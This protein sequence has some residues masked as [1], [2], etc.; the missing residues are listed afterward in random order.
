LSVEETRTRLDLAQKK[1]D[2]LR[3]EHG[4]L[5]PLMEKG[6]ITRDEL[7][8][9]A[10]ELEQAEEELVL[11][12]RR[13]E[14]LLEQTRPRDKQRAELQLAQ[15]EAQRENVRARLEEIG[16]RGQMLQEQGEHCSLFARRPG[17]VVFEEYLAA[18][19]RRKIRV[20]DR[21]TGSQGL[22]TIPEVN[23]ML[24]EASASEADVHRI[25]PGQTAAIRLEAF[26]DLR[27]T[28]KVTRVGTLARSDERPIDDKRFDVTI[29][30]DFTDAELRPEMTARVDI[31]TSE[32]AD[33]LLIPV[34]AV[35]D[36]QGSP[37]CHVTTRRGVET[38]P[39]QLGASSETH[40]EVVAGLQE[41]ERV[42]LMDVAGGEGAA[43]AP[44]SLT[45]AAPL[46]SPSQGNRLAPR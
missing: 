29:E 9:T 13:S 8:R 1:V 17:M 22:V 45:P 43:P 34:N 3:E 31:L 15:R 21:V 41:G 38:R 42:A 20:G 35:F 40:V 28:G 33:V 14:I 10:D 18:N 46:R 6:F 11:T 39:V 2:R 16:A 23:R 37:V 19:P 44:Q 24:V 27:L 4:Q 36:R 7:K 5:Q 32:R 25:T 26:P 30:V 12:R